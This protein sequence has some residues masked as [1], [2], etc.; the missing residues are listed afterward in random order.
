MMQ[1]KLELE[2][3]K[4]ALVLLQRALV[5]PLAITLGL[6]LRWGLPASCPRDLSHCHP[7]AL[8]LPSPN[9]ALVPAGI[10]RQYLLLMF[11]AGT[12]A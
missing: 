2:E 8:P 12:T 7:T 10:Q 9:M 3:K 4:Q 6:Q 5:R 11:P 1:L